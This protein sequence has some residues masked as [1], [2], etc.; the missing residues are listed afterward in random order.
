MGAHTCYPSYIRETKIGG[1]WFRP[2]YLKSETLQNNQEKKKGAGG[3]TQA[4]EYLC[5]EH[6]KLCFCTYFCP[7]SRVLSLVLSK[8]SIN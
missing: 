1:F 7:V 3:M 8:R 5:N 6:K 4:E 2:A